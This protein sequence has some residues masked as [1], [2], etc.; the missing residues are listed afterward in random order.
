MLSLKD[1][2][3]DQR[4]LSIFYRIVLESQF[5]VGSHHGIPVAFLEAL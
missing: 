3:T 2:S 5:R 4:G 1:T